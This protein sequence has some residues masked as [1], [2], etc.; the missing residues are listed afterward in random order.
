MSLSLSLFRKRVRA[1]EQRGGPAH[2][3][4]DGAE[5]PL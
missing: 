4:R 1:E 2:G 5:R 3:R